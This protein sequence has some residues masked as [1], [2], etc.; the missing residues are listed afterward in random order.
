MQVNKIFIEKKSNKYLWKWH[1]IFYVGYGVSKIKYKVI[2][3]ISFNDLPNHY[4]KFWLGNEIE[5]YYGEFLVLSYLDECDTGSLSLYNLQNK[6][7][8]N[9]NYTLQNRTEISRDFFIY[10]NRHFTQQGDDY[11]GEQ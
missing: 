10:I 6:N 3:I 8:I 4:L 7:W 9:L 11:A 1:Y 5:K 2:K